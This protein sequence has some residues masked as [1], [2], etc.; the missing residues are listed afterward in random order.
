MRF[1]EVLMSTEEFLTVVRDELG[2]AVTAEDMNQKFHD[3][4]GWDSIYLLWLIVL[5]EKHTGRKINAIDVLEASDLHHV[6][7]LA[8]VR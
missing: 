4:T 3:L 2:L 5:I 6:Y 7:E 8:A 1:L